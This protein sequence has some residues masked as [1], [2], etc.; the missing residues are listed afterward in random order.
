MLRLLL[1]A[2]VSL[3]PVSQALRYETPVV[4]LASGVSS[5]KFISFFFKY[6]FF[7]LLLAALGLLALCRRSPAVAGRGYSPAVIHGF[8]SP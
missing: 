7:I 1:A 8:S 4:P 6:L 5:C 3:S 2:V